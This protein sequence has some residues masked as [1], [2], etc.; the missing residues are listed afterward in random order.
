MRLLDRYVLR[1]FLQAYLYCIAGFISIWFIFDISDKLSTF[2][3]E[4]IS[5]SLIA[6][7]Y[8]TQAPQILVILLPVALLLAL[9]FCL[10]RMS[11][12]NEIVSMLTAGVSL[13]R[14][15]APL[16]LAGLATTVAST[17][18]NYSLAPHA[19]Y[20]RKTVLEDPK[21]RR[22]QVGLLAQIFRNRTDN[23]TWFIQQFKPGENL[24]RTVHIVQQDA[25]DNIVTNYIAT[26][27]VYHP[28]TKAWELQTVKV[29]HYDETGNITQT[30]MS[31]SL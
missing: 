7:Y 14:L 1:N 8:L 28:E 12:A 30:A 18:L 20:A 25:N 27:A 9:L 5:R 21:S 16:L 24:F 22:Q 4:R 26:S 29:V 13:P 3:D 19:E 23:R 31:E 17:V 2:M 6:K 11:R 10:G 15:V